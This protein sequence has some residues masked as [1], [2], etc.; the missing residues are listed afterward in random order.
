MSSTTLPIN[1]QTYHCICTSLLLATTH[2][3]STLPRRAAPSRDAAI[4]LPLPSKPPSFSS[5]EA[6]EAGK[7]VAREDMPTEGYSTLLGIVQ[8]PKP[9]IIRRED[10]FEKRL[11]FRC[12]RCSLVVGYEILGLEKS[13]GEGHAGS[14][15]YLL[16]AGTVSTEVMARGGPA[17]N[18]EKWINGS[19]IEIGKPGVVTV[20]E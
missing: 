7:R 8:D 19:H 20:F 9:T 13:A 4:I 11:M 15:M 16:P 10:G 2:T 14:V 5:A 1:I 6:G 3:L 17:E 18:G 12:S